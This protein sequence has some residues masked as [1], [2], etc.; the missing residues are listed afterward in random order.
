[1]RNLTEVISRTRASVS[2]HRSRW[3]LLGGLVALILVTLI[4]STT[5]SLFTLFVYDSVLLACLGAIALNVLMGTAGQVSIGNAAFLLVGAFSAVIAMRAGISA[6]LDLVVAA[7]VSGIV[8]AVVGLP[9]L[10]LRSLFL[11]LATLAAFFIVL[12]AGNE[13]Q[14]SVPSAASGGFIVPTTFASHGLVGSERYW[15]WLLTALV[16]GVLLGA[17][18]LMHHR[19]ARAWRLIRDHEHI[20]PTLGINV[21]WYK[22][23]IFVLSSMV[24]GVQ[25]A[26]TAHFTGSVTTDNFSLLL[27]VQYIAMI[28]IGGLDSLL[29]AVLGAA[30][31]VALPSIVPHVIQ[32]LVGPSR[33][34]TVGPQVSQI[35][36]GALIVLFVTASPRGIVGWVTGRRSGG[37]GRLSTMKLRRATAD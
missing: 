18:R 12:F 8:G 31:V 14:S 28:L 32:N 37:L 27:S 6:P 10:R 3:V 23:S 5:S 30:L 17:N 1:V 24:I 35:V 4:F 7:G 9:A 22:R 34:A 20:A 36:Y 33:A 26:L 25:G 13:Y 19:A 16:I 2:D 21:T 11:A 15:A 29:G